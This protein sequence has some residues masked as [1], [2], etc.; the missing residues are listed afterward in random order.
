MA[1]F[2]ATCAKNNQKIEIQVQ[3]NSIEEAR[4]S[5]HKQWYSIIE[6]KEVS[7]QVSGS[8]AVFYC[9]VIMEWK[10][11]V[12]Q[13]NSNDIFQAYV[14][15]VDI[16]NYN[17][18][19]IYDN[20]ERTEKEKIL[21]TQKVKNSYQIYKNSKRQQEIKKEE[22]KPKEV[23]EA[24]KQNSQYEDLPN[25]LVKELNNYYILIDKVLEKI[26][27]IL[28]DFKDNIS[29]EKRI[30]L[31]ELYNGLKQVKNITNVT[32]LK[33]IWEKSLLKIWE[34]QTELL[35]QDV[36]KWKKNILWDT[37]KLLKWF[38]SSKQ[39]VL[40]EDDIKIKLNSILADYWE[41][42]KS[43]FKPDKK[44][45]KID[46]NS[47]KYFD[48]L[49]EKNIYERKLKEINKEIM[50]NVFN[51]E[52]KK[53]LNLKKKLIRQ[54][55]SILD[56]RI[57]N[58]KISYSKT[59]KWFNYYKD[60]ILYV[61]QKISDTIIY[62]L[63]IYSI[64]FIFL[65]VYLQLFDKDLK[66]NYNFLLYI[67]LFSMFW[68]LLKISKNFIIFVFSTLIYIIFFIYLIINF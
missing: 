13:I 32:K 52:N 4:A 19:Y 2:K 56:N 37:N 16:L 51:I 38:W 29:E 27:L 11:K 5:L 14:Q 65:N 43:I 67:A 58:K 46:K 64:F 42:L 41:S 44:V 60:V 20:K 28:I 61:F 66:F 47:W 49:R 48:I 50:K 18:V 62:A 7:E 35:S 17:V 55:I 1:F 10:L 9:D 21:I 45:E 6:L 3:F 59:I 23:S 26:D 34:L 63:L 15:L 24:T 12:W 30:K 54:N 22:E 8:E 53:R 31:W 68:F 36:M 40:P 25:F 33:M 39:I 57:K